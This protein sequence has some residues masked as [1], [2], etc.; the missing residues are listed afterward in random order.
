[1]NLYIKWAAGKIESD[2]KAN[3]LYQTIKNSK[4]EIQ[5]YDTKFIDREFELLIDFLELL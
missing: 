3:E 2:E 4:K 1:M 5:P